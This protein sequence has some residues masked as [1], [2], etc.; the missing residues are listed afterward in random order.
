MS[1]DTLYLYCG[2]ETTQP[3]RP[4]GPELWLQYLANKNAT[5]PVI[6]YFR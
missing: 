6:S 5:C 2:S 1:P 3:L 4:D